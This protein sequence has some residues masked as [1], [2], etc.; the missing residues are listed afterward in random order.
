MAT[1]TKQPGDALQPNEQEVDFETIW[2]RSRP[3]VFGILTALVLAAGAFTVYTYLQRQQEEAE[4]D[5]QARLAG[6]R[7][8]SDLQTIVQKYPQS[9]AASYALILMGAQKSQMRDWPGSQAA[10]SK[11]IEVTKHP[12]FKAAARYGLGV[13]L[14]GQGKFDQAIQEYGRV[15]QEQP[16]SYKAPEAE[17][18]VGRL[19]EATGKWGDAEKT[20]ENL[21]VAY[22]QSFW[23]G[24]AD[25]RLKIIR[26]RPAKASAPAPVPMPLPTPPA[27]PAR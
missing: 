13:A 1:F 3:W 9:D 26:A 11:L 25:E 6:A 10:Y 27:P 2:Q 22:P 15:S 4:L 23:K 7:S 8:E 21:T 24:E 5:A 14:E 17:L 19:Q 12:D 20:Y 16:K 18:A